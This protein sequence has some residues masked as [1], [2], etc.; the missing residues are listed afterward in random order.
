VGQL[1]PL[2]RGPLTPHEQAVLDAIPLARDTHLALADVAGISEHQ[3]ED[4]LAQLTR[5]GLVHR[6]VPE[7]R[8]GASR[9]A[10]PASKHNPEPPAA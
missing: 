2:A 8:R 1:T 9:R 4:T 3:L 7:Y 10:R 5:R 6:V